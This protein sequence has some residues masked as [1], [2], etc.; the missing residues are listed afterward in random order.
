MTKEIESGEAEVVLAT[1]PM[2]KAKPG[3]AADAV[4]E[5]E[6]TPW[7]ESGWFWGVTGGV[8]TAGAAVIVIVVLVKPAAQAQAEP[9]QGTVDHV[10]PAVL[11]W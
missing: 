2:P 8:V 5:E 7:Y 6:A 10:V 9:P 1:P 3:A 4:P 11:R